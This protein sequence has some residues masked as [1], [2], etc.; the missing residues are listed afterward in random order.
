MHHWWDARRRR[1]DL[2]KCSLCSDLVICYRERVNNC[3]N[4]AA[5]SVSQRS[6]SMCRC[7]A[8]TPHRW[9]LL[10]FNMH[11]NKLVCYLFWVCYELLLLAAASA[12][13]FCWF[14]SRL[15]NSLCHFVQLGCD[16]LTVYKLGL[17]YLLAQWWTQQWEKHQNIKNKCKFSQVMQQEYHEQ[18]LPQSTLNQCCWTKMFHSS[19]KLLYCSV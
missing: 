7:P 14:R 11:L 9:L 19:V 13:I 10:C 4:T 17:V 15:L 1:G 5:A 2:R 12:E 18:I 16:S 6:L 3:E 8:I